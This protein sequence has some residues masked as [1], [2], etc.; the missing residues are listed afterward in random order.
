MLDAQGRVPLTTLVEVLRAHR[1]D[2]LRGGEVEEV[3]RLDARRFDIDAGLIRARYGHSVTLEQPGPA[4]RPPE[5][6]YH[7]V[8]AGELERV[9]AAGL[10]P[11]RR[12][13]VH[14]CQTPQEA[15]RL[16]ERHAV[17]GQVVTV[18]ARRAHDRGVPI[19]QAT[20]RLYLAPQV[21][22]EFLHLP[23][24]VRGAGPG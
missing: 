5:W 20:E 13:S 16:L 1:W 21:P 23:A 3:I 9:R 11:E 15:A 22:A 8:P 14:L 24:P 19:Y 10:R 4:V 12:Q 17:S 18:F 2:D 7:A 6:L